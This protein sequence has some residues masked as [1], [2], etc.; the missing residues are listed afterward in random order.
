MTDTYQGMTAQEWA[1]MYG[2]AIRQHQQE[3]RSIHDK[4]QRD[5]AERETIFGVVSADDNATVR[6]NSY[7][8]AEF[9]AG[10]HDGRHVVT[11]TV[12]PWKRITTATETEN[13]N[14]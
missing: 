11:R 9:L 2:D 5:H 14:L 12:T 3:L 8:E 13:P 4:Q 6:A 7:A 10:L 1:G